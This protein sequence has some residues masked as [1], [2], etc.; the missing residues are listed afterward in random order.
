[1]PNVQL[2]RATVKDHDTLF[3]LAQFYQY[4]F[5]DYLPGEL[6]E[7]GCYPYINVRFYLGQGRQAYL[8]RVD[9]RLAGFVLVDENPPYRGGVG[10]YLAEF[11]VMRRYR[12]QG[13]G[14]AMAIQTFDT[15]KGYWE[16]AEVGPNV[17]AQAFWRA[18]IRDYSGGRFQEIITEEDGLKIVWQTFDSRG[19]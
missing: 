17:P 4:D 11:F 13:V 15:Y 6:D 18:V 14:R 10:H 5:T 7:D 16:I 1:M 8:A 19:W 3:N 2:V 12:R 9:Q